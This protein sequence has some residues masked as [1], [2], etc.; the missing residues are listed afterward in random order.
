MPCQ[1]R[2]IFVMTSR[3]ASNTGVDAP[4]NATVRI[5]PIGRE[6]VGGEAARQ[7]PASFAFDAP[8]LCGGVTESSEFDDEKPG[9]LG[10]PAR[11]AVPSD[12][13]KDSGHFVR[14]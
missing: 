11:Q 13:F 4:V 2:M 8:F 12:G 14:E 5:A 10:G 7:V 9:V 1:S 6:I 3:T